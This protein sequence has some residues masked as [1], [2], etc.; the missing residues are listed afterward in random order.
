MSNRVQTT[1]RN[2]RSPAWGRVQGEVTWP[3]TG[4]AE[5]RA[6]REEKPGKGA[7]FPTKRN[8]S[9]LSSGSIIL[10][11][12]PFSKR[13]HSLGHLPPLLSPLYAC[14]PNME[15][16]V[17]IFL[18]LLGLQSCSTLM[19][20]VRDSFFLIPL[21]SSYILIVTRASSNWTRRWWLCLR[22]LQICSLLSIST[23]F[24]NITLIH[25]M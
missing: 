11:T 21:L 6:H 24:P 7:S 14:S 17:Y 13:R 2:V 5:T 3:F 18:N 10:W 23:F 9:L 1:S 4:D 22:D 8:A 20:G 15:S 12:L 16:N 25:C 19:N